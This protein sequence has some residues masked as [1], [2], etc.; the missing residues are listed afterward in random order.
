MQDRAYAV[1][2]VTL[3]A[4]VYVVPVVYVARISSPLFDVS[5]FEDLIA[6]FHGSMVVACLAGQVAARYWG[7]LLLR[8]FLL[9]VFASTD[10]EPRAYLGPTAMRRLAMA[11]LGFF[12]LSVTTIFVATGLFD[13]V[14]TGTYAFACAALVS[15]T[16]S[17]V[18]L[19]AQ[20]HSARANGIFL[21][22][23]LS[24]VW[25]VSISS[26]RLPSLE[27]YSLWVTIAIFGAGLSC[28]ARSAARSLSRIDLEVL[29]RDSARASRAQVFASM[30]TFHYALEL[31][32][33][34]PRGLTTSLV[35]RDGTL[36]GHLVQGAIRSLRTPMRVVAG[37]GVLLA[38]GF[39][40]FHASIVSEGF[41]PWA[42]I[43]LG[44]MIVYVGSGW[45]GEGWRSLLDELTLVPL[46]GS[47]WGGLLARTILWPVI[48]VFSGVSLGAIVAGVGLLPFSVTAGLTATAFIFMA[49]L[50]VLAARFLSEMKTDLPIE[51]LLPM[52]TPIGDLSGIRVLAWQFD[53]LIALLVGISVVQAM[54]TMA[55]SLVCTGI[56]CIYCLCAGVRRAGVALPRFGLSR[57]RVLGGRVCCT[58]R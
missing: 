29:R 1:Y 21:A 57:S 51:L 31:Y 26:D 44:S 54:P 8:P 28:V 10:L 46:Y 56:V 25:G 14:R 47:T 53:G 45:V 2:I 20:I 23:A 24:V 9:Y 27:T 34:E 16:V 36:R 49:V 41:S 55:W 5:S 43:A 17:I 35:R 12:T 42:L 22:G 48:A 19:W 18:W 33:P 4:A 40:L 50:I 58:N 30:G 15:L 37:A 3:L 11:A 6:M 7:P 38:G 52:P 13:S 32:L 39:V